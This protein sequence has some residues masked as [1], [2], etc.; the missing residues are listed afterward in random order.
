[1]T[2]QFAQSGI[3][4]VEFLWLSEHQIIAIKADTK[5]QNFQPT[6]KP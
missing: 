6:I 5:L 1:M 4:F 2:K 3:V